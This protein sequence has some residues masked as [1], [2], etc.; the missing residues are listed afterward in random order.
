MRPSESSGMRES[1]APS[2]SDD[3]LTVSGRLFSVRKSPRLSASASDR[4]AAPP[5]ENAARSLTHPLS[6]SASTA[7]AET[8]EE[9]ACHDPSVA[10][11]RSAMPACTL[12]TLV[13]TAARSAADS[14]T[15][16]TVTAVRTR[17]RASVRR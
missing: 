7:E 4:A 2:G 9:N 11:V 5:F 1:G 13:S 8:S 10:R 15:P 6:A 16:A 14:A 17:F 3:P 12:A